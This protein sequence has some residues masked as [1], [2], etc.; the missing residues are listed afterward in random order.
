MRG[1]AV[2]RT[3]VGGDGSGGGDVEGKK[4]RVIVEGNYKN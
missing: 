1:E 4:G 2:G 3:I